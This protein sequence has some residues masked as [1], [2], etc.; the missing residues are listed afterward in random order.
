MPKMLGK[1][2]R[3][4]MSLVRRWPLLICRSPLASTSGL[5]LP[6]A[7]RHAEVLAAFTGQALAA[8]AERGAS[9]VV[10]DFLGGAEAA[11]WPVD[12]NVMSTFDPGMRLENRW[13]SL[14]EYL[15][16]GDKKDRQHYKRTLREAGK[17]GIR[18]ERRAQP[19][20]IAPALALIRQVESSHGAL[21]NPWT[22]RMLEHMHMVGGSFLAASINERL[23]GCGLLVE[24]NASQMT[25]ALGLAEDVPYVYFMLVY[26]SLK[27]AF[28]RGAR[29]LR[30]GSGATD[31]KQRLGF[32]P[33]D[34]GSLSFAAVSPVLRKL[35]LWVA[36]RR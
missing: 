2:R 21:P 13:G 12:Y 22:G 26:E 9:F 23:V 8:A 4:A 7:E 35:F 16:D 14:E 28:E 34:N 25:T 31:V 17:L 29:S 20:G 6:E 11:K 32:S 24:D 36:R 27:I 19:E 1:L 3:P 33:E 30:W 5:I 10:F 15:A 18:I